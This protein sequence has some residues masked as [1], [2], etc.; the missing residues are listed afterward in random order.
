MF[1]FFM[2]LIYA[3][4][5]PLGL[6][7]LR[8]TREFTPLELR[9]ST[10]CVQTLPVGVGDAELA[11]PRNIFSTIQYRYRYHPPEKVL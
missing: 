6:S 3:G 4:E 1:L 5:A 10:K 7:G 8:V 11:E 9:Y 2:D